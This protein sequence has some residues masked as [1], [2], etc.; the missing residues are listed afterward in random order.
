MSRDHG[1]R[2]VVGLHPVRELLRAERPVRRILLDAERSE[3]DVVDDIVALARSRAVPVERVSRA[4][5]DQQAEG[6]THQGVLAVAPSFPYVDLAHMISRAEAADE[7]PFLLALDG[8]TDPHNLGAIARTAEVVGAHGLIV[9][10]R[11]AAN[12]TPTV[13]K[14][15]AGALAHLPIARVPNMSYA[16]RTLAETHV[17]SVGLDATATQSLFACELLTEPLVLVIGSEGAGLARSSHVHCDMLVRLPVT[18]R[19]SSLNASVAAGVAA[20]EVRRR[21]MTPGAL[22]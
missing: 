19:L 4:R 1:D 8:I 22:E 9:P 18:G 3:T 11:R 14:A 2:L 21:R 15:A 12:V 16:L 17:W 20:Y 6:H 10:K 13:E 7:A 5:I